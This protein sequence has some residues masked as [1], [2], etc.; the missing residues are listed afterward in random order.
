M[1]AEPLASLALSVRLSAPLLGGTTCNR[2]ACHRA[3]ATSLA[4]PRTASFPATRPAQLASAVLLLWP[5]PAR[6]AAPSPE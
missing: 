2:M 4:W 5:L 3:R 1:L 6:E